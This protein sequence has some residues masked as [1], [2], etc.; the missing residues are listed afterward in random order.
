[1]DIISNTRLRYRQLTFLAVLI[2]LCITTY[3]CLAT[4]AME[5]IAEGEMK[6]GKYF[7]L[8][9]NDGEYEIIRLWHPSRR[10]TVSIKRSDLPAGCTKAR[11]FLN[12]LSTEL[13]VARI[14]YASWITG[15]K[16]PLPD[17]RYPTCAMLVSYGSFSELPESEGVFITS[18]AGLV[19]TGNREEPHP[20]AWALFPVSTAADFYLMVGGT[21]ALP[22]LL[23]TAFI[24]ENQ[25]NQLKEKTKNELPDSVVSCWAAINDA[26]EKR[27][28]SSEYPLHLVRFEWKPV[29]ENSYE[30]TSEAGIFSIDQPVLIDAKATLFHGSI[31]FY[32]T[33]Y[34]LHS[35]WTDADVECGLKDGNVVATYVRLYK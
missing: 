11:F 6:G 28:T 27:E 10:R 25:D 19:A 15:T 17:E 33:D 13:L 26:I 1:M 7:I 18:I 3:G 34:S 23:P 12:E 29:S 14:S 30:Q 32:P 31:L 8:T 20:A 4:S 35:F 22:V 24:L 21:L 16:P 2:L 9:V 5:Q